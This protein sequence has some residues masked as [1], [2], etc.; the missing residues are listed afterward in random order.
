L[1]K[2]K[3]EQANRGKMGFKNIYV[4]FMNLENFDENFMIFG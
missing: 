2:K 1:I 3:L 4:F